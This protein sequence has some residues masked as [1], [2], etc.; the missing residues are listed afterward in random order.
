[1]R[2]ENE[3]FEAARWASIIDEMD[4]QACTLE[5]VMGVGPSGHAIMAKKTIHQAMGSDT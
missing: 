3:L 1:M 4:Q 2:I 5:I